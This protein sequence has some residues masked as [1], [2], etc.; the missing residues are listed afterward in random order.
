MTVKR[1]SLPRSKKKI[2]QELL[3]DFYI[4]KKYSVSKISTIIKCSQNK[5]NYW[6]TKYGIKKRTIADAMYVFKNPL[7]DPFLF[8]K[9]RNKK[10]Y[11]LYGMGL[12]LYWGEGEKRGSGG[13]RLSNTDPNLLNKF[14]E[15]LE[16]IFSVERSRLRFGLQIFR[17]IEPDQ[18]LE[19][20]AKTLG[21]KK[22]QF[23]KI[24]I[25]KVR[26]KGTY[27]NKSEYGVIVIYFN[28]VKLK[29]LLCT[30]IENV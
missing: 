10:E 28:N 30:M 19:Y 1:I 14:I 18:A 15:F 13:L 29:R 7:G 17:D 21:V 2:T 11:I 24:M 12:A 27:K 26:G 3:F 9:P 22:E 8:R 4:V 16:I 25:S 23:Y 6:L 20:W 5:I